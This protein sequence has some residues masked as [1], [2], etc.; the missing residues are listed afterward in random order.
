[1]KMKIELNENDVRVV[2]AEYIKQQ[3]GKGVTKNDVRLEVENYIEDR[4]CGGSYPKFK[5]AIVNVEN[6]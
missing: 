6:P 2:I 1:M 3:Y 5:Q 4:P